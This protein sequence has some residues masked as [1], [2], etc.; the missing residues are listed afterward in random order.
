MSRSSTTIPTA[1]QLKRSDSLDLLSPTLS[2]TGSLSH[3]YDSAALSSDDEEDFR[4]ISRQVASGGNSLNNGSASR[5]PN[6][7]GSRRLPQIMS[8]PFNQSSVNRSEYRY[9]HTRLDDGLED[10]EVDQ[11]NHDHDARS[12]RSEILGD[13]SHKR[14]YI[15]SAVS[16][17]VALAAFVMQTEAV[18]YIEQDLKF[19]KPIFMLYV[20]HSS[21]IIMFPLQLI[22]LNFLSPRHSFSYIFTKHQRVVTSTLDV[23]ASRNNAK[24]SPLRYL[25]RTV[26]F[27]TFALTIAGS[28]WY[29]SEN[30]TTPSDVTAIYNCSAFF[31]YVFSVPILKE[32]FNW[33]KTFSVVLAI[34][35]V[36]IVAYGDSLSILSSNNETLSPGEEASNRLFGNIIIGV[37]AVMYGLYEV[38]YKRFACP[39][40]TVSARRAT[41]FANVFGS[42]VGLFTLTCLWVLLPILHILGVEEF[43]VPKGETLL[44]LIFS[45][46]ANVAYSGSFLI[47]MSLTSPVI[48]SVAA[49]LTIFLVALTDWFLF[50]APLD[51][52]TIVGGLTIAV[53]FALLA[54]S[55]W[56]EIGGYVDAIADEDLLVAE[57]RR[58]EVERPDRWRVPREALMEDAESS[59]EP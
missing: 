41:L 7:F 33:V 30:L 6:K 39:P 10:D 29:I 12:M 18:T 53:A 8:S 44:I 24:V 49:L 25:I 36:L 16:L 54:A 20:T 50:E 35:G 34:I 27:I 48:S 19:Q 55:S 56:R 47:L 11:T 32:R 40:P 37:G 1:T 3:G 23:I 22:F 5:A 31:A 15:Y 57:G 43:E 45:V 9:L 51:L 26:I 46:L 52:G 59:N 2:A 17:V 58:L 4:S 28:T 21:W 14:R 13:I 38:L 42:C